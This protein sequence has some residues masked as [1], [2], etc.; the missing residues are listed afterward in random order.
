MFVM[1]LAGVRMRIENRFEFME[2]Q[3][4]AYVCEDG[5][6]AFS[7]AVTEEE[8]ADWLRAIERIRPRQVQIYSIDRKTPEQ[9]LEKVPVEELRAIGER[10]KA[11]G[12]DINVAG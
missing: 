9:S 5:E 2:K 1:E 7:V 3:C 11:L 4:R 8:I 6:V 10:V 12:I